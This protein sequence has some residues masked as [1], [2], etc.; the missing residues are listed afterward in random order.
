[1][2]DLNEKVQPGDERTIWKPSGKR[3]PGRPYKKFTVGQM[4]KL[5]MALKGG[6][7]R[8]MA[9]RW[10]GI[11]LTTFAKRLQDDVRFKQIVDDAEAHWEISQMSK[12]TTDTDPKSA[13]WALGH[14]PRTRQQFGD[15]QDGSTVNVGILNGPGGAVSFDLGVMLERLE[16][17][18]LDPN[19][20][21][22]PRPPRALVAAQGSVPQTDPTIIDAEIVTP[23]RT[24]V[25]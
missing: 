12:I 6:A 5:I 15:N 20:P 10:C 7:T 21:R 23:K 22:D 3:G 16:Q 11:N 1:M 19:A 8:S 13:R 17:R 2:S 4:K 18:R 24:P 9:C 14:H 25:R